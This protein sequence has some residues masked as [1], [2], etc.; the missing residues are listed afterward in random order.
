MPAARSK[1]RKRALD[2]LF[3]AELRDV[4]VLDLLAERTEMASPPVPEYAAELV[5]GVTEHA[6]RINELISEFAEGWT[7]DRMPAVDRNLLRI[8]IYELLWAPEV[9]DG[10]AISEAVALARD[11]STDGSAAFVNGLLA[12]IADLKP[13]LQ[14]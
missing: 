3:E 6:A 9:P 4:P 2:I 5:R 11:L 13:S 1:A 10:V 14:L 7:L 12:R 8:G